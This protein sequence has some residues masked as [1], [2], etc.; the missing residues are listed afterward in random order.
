M[1]QLEINAVVGEDGS[2]VFNG[3]LQLCG[4][5]VPQLLGLSCCEHV[6]AVRSQ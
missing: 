4:I 5:C 2:L 3:I 6:K 1:E